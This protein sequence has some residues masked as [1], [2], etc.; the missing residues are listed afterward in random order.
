[1]RAKGIEVGRAF[2]PLDDWVRISIGLPHENAMARAVIAE[3]L[4]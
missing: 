2:P 3:L 4:R 1:M